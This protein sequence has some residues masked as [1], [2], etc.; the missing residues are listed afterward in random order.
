MRSGTIIAV[1]FDGTLC[2]NCWPNIGEPNYELI[3]HLMYCRYHGAKL[4]LWTCREG[5]LLDKAL[6]WCEEIGLLFDAVNDNIP[7]SIE[8]YGSN[9]RKVYADIYID[10]LSTK[11]FW[12]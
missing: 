2:K 10:D 4:I 7:E 11:P 3:D 1:D 9:C 6:E 8:K 12:F 5:Y